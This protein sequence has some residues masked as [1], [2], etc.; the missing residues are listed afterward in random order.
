MALHG[1][2]WWCMV[3]HGE[4]WNHLFL[5]SSTGAARGGRRGPAAKHPTVADSG[6]RRWVLSVGLSVVS[7]N[8]Q[9]KE[10]ALLHL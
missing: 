9:K 8:V 4:P 3:V 7:S 10:L 6:G 1:G 2:A 5:E